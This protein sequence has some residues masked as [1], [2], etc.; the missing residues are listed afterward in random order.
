ML[1]TGSGDVLANCC[2]YIYTFI[3]CSCILKLLSFSGS[4]SFLT[5]P[6]S[7]SEAAKLESEVSGENAALR[8]LAIC[9]PQVKDTWNQLG[10]FS[11]TGSSQGCP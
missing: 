10:G 1:V 8:H 3:D 11:V 5:S 2:L 4:S 6:L 9:V 7:G